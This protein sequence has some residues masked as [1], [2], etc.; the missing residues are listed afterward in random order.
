MNNAWG[1]DIDNMLLISK[2]NKRIQFL[3][4]Y[5]VFS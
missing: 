4:C 5:G 2:Y 1:A 3:L